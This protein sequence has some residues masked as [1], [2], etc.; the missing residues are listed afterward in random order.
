MSPQAVR[1]RL[2][3]FRDDPWVV[4][5]AASQRY[6]E[7][8]LLVLEDGKIRQIGEASALLPGLPPATP[9]D[10]YRGHLVMAGFIDS[11]IHYSQSQVIAS[12]GAQLLDWLETYA[13][14]EEQ[15]FADPAHG[16]RMAAFFLDELLRNGTTT[17]AVYCTSHPCAVEAF[18]TAA[19]ERNMRMI[20]GKLLMDRSAPTALLDTAQSGYD[21]SRALIAA[22]QGR[23]RA[24]YAITP[25]FAVTSSEAQLE[26]AG[27]LLGEHQGVYMQTHLAEN[28]REAEAVAKLF[29][30]CESYTAV[31]DRFGL[32]GPHS[33][34]GHCIHLED[35]E[36]M[37]LSESGSVAVF[38]PTSN[39]FIGS[40]LFDGAR[41]RDARF[42]L[43]TALA[44]DVGGG[45]SYSM[46]R[47]A[48]EAYKVLQLQGD[49]LAPLQAFYEITL[50]NA[51]A[52]DLDR[53]IGALEVGIE[54]DLV[55]LDARA[56]PAMAHRME[57]VDGDLAEE[58][59]VL[60]TLGDD[61][62]VRAT[63][64]AGERLHKADQTS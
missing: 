61:R 15:K 5:E 45:T 17:A 21:D 49:N 37:R 56:T 53:H 43:R 24:H 23:G 4:G 6:W 62:S 26:A 13:F 44:T 50:G 64:V 41:A 63:Y 27:A 39:L 25:R 47:T 38:C 12:Y 57:T 20:A 42:P 10:D 40:G 58:L 14:A 35:S 36:R 55:V 1:G 3:S 52:L 59:F 7:D 16:A 9:I 18:F 54:A 2:L 22:W 46:L 28:R 30:D 11:H 51:R 60:M 29:P 19:G 34:F 48:G 33:L 8:G 32:L 31:Y